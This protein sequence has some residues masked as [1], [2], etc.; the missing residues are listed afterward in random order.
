MG[1]LLEY[2]SAC[3]QLHSKQQA[4][5][6]DLSKSISHFDLKVSV[7]NGPLNLCLW[8]PSHENPNNTGHLTSHWIF[9]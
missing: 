7:Y 4:V 5:I 2:S 3:F 9:N 1:S 6:K 8:M